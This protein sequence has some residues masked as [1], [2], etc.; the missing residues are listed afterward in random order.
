MQCFEVMGIL[1]IRHE[2]FYGRDFL[3]AYLRRFL[4]SA[5][6]IFWELYLVALTLKTRVFEGHLFRH[7][8]V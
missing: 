5:R 8:L 3:C 6:M 7:N 1:E 4:R 2:A